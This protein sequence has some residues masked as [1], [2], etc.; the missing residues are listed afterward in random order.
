MCDFKPGDEVVCIKSATKP[1]NPTRSGQ[2]YVVESVF[3]N[4]W[5]GNFALALVGVPNGGE[6]NREAGFWGHRSDRFRPVTRTRDTLSIESFMTIK[7]G[8]PEGPRRVVGPV[9]P[10]VEEVK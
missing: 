7:T 8:Q 10:K 9:S 2:T 3:F 5:S 4:Q 6:F 1:T